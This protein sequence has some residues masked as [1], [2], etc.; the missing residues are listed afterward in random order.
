MRKNIISE[1]EKIIK[2]AKAKGLPTSTILQSM[3]QY[4]NG[5]E[6]VSHQ[7]KHS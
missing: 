7:R 5:L 2:D 6:Q 1:V 4:I 3:N